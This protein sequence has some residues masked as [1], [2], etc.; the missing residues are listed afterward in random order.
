MDITAGILYKGE[1]LK[2]QFSEG[3]IVAGQWAYSQGYAPDD[4][5]VVLLLANGS[6]NHRSII[7]VYD[8]QTGRYILENHYTTCG[9]FHLPISAYEADVKRIKKEYSDSRYDVSCWIDY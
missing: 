9:T 2:R 6:I 8:Y 1:L 5:K 4:Y 3:S 7:Q